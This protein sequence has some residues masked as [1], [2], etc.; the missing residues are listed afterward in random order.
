MTIGSAEN[1]KIAA[2]TGGDNPDFTRLVE[3]QKL[4]LKKFHSK[5][6]FYSGVF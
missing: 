2:D 4:I 3:L 6:R 5:V 1:S